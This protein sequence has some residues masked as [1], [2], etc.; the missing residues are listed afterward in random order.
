MKSCNSFSLKTTITYF[1]NIIKV[2]ILSF[3]NILNMMNIGR[4]SDALG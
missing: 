3:K 2:E 4:R 1:A